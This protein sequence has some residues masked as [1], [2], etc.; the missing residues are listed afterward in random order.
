MNIEAHTPWLSLRASLK[1]WPWFRILAHLGALLPLAILA[2]QAATGNLGAEPI[3]A[4]ILRTGKAALVL[5]ALSLACTPLNTVFGFKPALKVRRALGLYAFLY[6][7]VHLGILVGVDYA[8][9][10]KLLVEEV[11][12]KRFALA[13]LGAGLILQALAFTSFDAWKKRLGKNWKR[14]HRLVYLAGPLAA[15]HF[16]W[17][18]K[19]GVPE[20][21]YWLGGVLLLLA[22]RLPPVRRWLSRRRWR[23]PRRPAGG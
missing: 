19:Q 3:R 7:V 23:I 6:V 10:W 17:S 15:L 9:D 12:V 14:L 22:L 2:L 5:L 13:G 21:Y 16:I 18:V 4:S 11:L 8:F 20:P 1:N